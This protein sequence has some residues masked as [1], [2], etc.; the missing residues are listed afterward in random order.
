MSA[1][2]VRRGQLV[3]NHLDDPAGIPIY[4]G[5]PS[6]ASWIWLSGNSRFTLHPADIIKAIAC[7]CQAAPAQAAVPAEHKALMSCSTVPMFKTMESVPRT[8]VGGCVGSSSLIH[9]SVGGQLSKT[10]LTRDGS[11]WFTQTKKSNRDFDGA[12]VD[13]VAEACPF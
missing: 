13:R 4:R 1:V 9:C 10:F 7:N 2:E 3:C 11:W 12:S 5:G 8:C 6:D